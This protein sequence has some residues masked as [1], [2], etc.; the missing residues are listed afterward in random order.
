L[1]QPAH[2]VAASGLSQWETQCSCS[3]WGQTRQYSPLALAQHHQNPRLE[4]LLK[5]FQRDGSA[6]GTS[7]T[8]VTALQ[9]LLLCHLCEENE[10]DYDATLMLADGLP[11]APLVTLLRFGT[12][13]LSLSLISVS[14]SVCLSVSLSLSGH[15]T[16]LQLAPCLSGSIDACRLLSLAPRTQLPIASFTV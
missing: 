1:P 10:L 13:A 14:L 6:A 15:R 5:D 16:S 9:R 8:L 3:V 4:K 2:V 7:A 11:P 12:L